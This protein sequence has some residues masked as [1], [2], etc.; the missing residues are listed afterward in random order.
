MVRSMTGFGRCL[1]EDNDFVQQWEVR[2]VN[3]KHLDMRWHIPHNLRSLQ[4]RLEKCARKYAF[5][6]RVDISLV[7]QYKAEAERCI[8]FDIT[9][10][11]AMLNALST[12]AKHRQENFIPD[13][14]AFLNIPSLWSKGQDDQEEH[15]I[16]RLEEGLCLALEDWN[17]SRNAEGHTL[18]LDIHSML[19]RMTTWSDMIEEQIPTVKEEKINAL[20]TRL[21]EILSQ[22]DIDIDESRFLQEIV[23]LGDKLDVSE[24]LVRLRLH[25]QRLK[26]LLQIGEYIG[27]KLDFTL[28]ECF[29]E[30]NTCGNKI[31]DVQLS[32][33]VVDIKNELEKCREQA[34]N[35]E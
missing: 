24:E 20:R 30:I 23:I 21:T 16:Q 5:R 32:R 15:L 33:L 34:Q 26:E 2:S 1:V 13:Y 17:E 14:T 25:L 29:R 22:S 12:L 9:Q 18:G 7:L 10:A 28:Q 11:N 31:P 19:V 3:S 8:D 6:G 4:A 35:I 27:R